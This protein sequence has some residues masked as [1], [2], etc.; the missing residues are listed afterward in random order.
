MKTVAQL[1]K[2]HSK[3]VEIAKV[4]RD[5]AVAVAPVVTVI[6]AAKVVSDN[7]K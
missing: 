7:M 4:V 1:T 5:V 3:V 6:I 2:E